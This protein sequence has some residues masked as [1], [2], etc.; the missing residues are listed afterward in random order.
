LISGTSICIDS[1]QNNC[2]A[3]Y[4]VDGSE[5]CFDIAQFYNI[6]LDELYSLNPNVDSTN[7]ANIYVGEMLCVAPRASGPAP[8]V[9]MSCTRN[10]TIVIGDTCTSIAA[11]NSLT[12]IQLSQLN[13]DFS[14][15]ALIPSEQVCSFSPSLSICPDLV[16]VA[17]NDTCFDL[18]QAVQLSLDEWEGLNPGIDCDALLPGSVV[19]SAEGNATLPSAPSGTNPTAGKPFSPVRTPH[20]GTEIISHSSPLRFVQ[21]ENKLLY[22]IHRLRRP[23][24]RPVSA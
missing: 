8:P 19:C 6:P 5:G 3:V 7:C 24:Q 22:P 9:D 16:K 23:A 10:Y 18:A 13:P 17:V 20:I 11:K 4:K 21:Q 12:N 14:C 1:P 15:D 2:S